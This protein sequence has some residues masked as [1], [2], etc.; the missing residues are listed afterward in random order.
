MT[1]FIVPTDSV[2]AG[3]ALCD[4]LIDRVDGDDTVHAVYVPE[5][6]SASAARDGDDALNAVYARLGA[7]ATVETHRVDRG[8]TPAEGI[9]AAAMELGV[10]EIVLGAG[11]SPEGIG[12]VTEAVAASAD[13]PV[14][15]VPE[16]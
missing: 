5:D 7:V 15:V 9:R 6:P 12:S 3:A 14:V 16:A 4:Y 8:T 1:T 10:D 11:G 13:R 2:H